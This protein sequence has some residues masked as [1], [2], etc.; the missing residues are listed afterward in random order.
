M[1]N[2]LRHLAFQLAFAVVGE[3]IV[4]HSLKFF[5][6]IQFC[7]SYKLFQLFNTSDKFVRRILSF[8]LLKILLIKLGMT[9]LL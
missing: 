7:I 2:K 3:L 4:T 1:S 9:E 6:I 5:E 8:L